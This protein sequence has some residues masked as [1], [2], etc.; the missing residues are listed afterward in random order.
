MISDTK[1]NET[2]YECAAYIIDT[3]MDAVAHG[4]T[5]V[6]PLKIPWD[7]IRTLITE[8][9]GGKIDNEGDFKQLTELVADFITPAAFDID[10]RLV[11]GAPKEEAKVY[12]EGDGSLTV[13]EGNEMK[14]FLEW[15]NRLPEREPPTYLGL[16]ANAE[17]L[18]LVGHGRNTIT[19]LAKI[20][21]ILDESE[22]L[23]DAE[24]E[25]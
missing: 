11:K 3:W 8:T 2:Q 6:A 16:P 9:Y 12:S 21:N 1:T 20:T 17:K 14:D 19:N 24:V 7:L 13:P 23:S 5:N 4:R 10:H 22:Q 18:L 15:V 25:K